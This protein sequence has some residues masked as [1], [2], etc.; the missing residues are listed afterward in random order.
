MFCL[1]CEAASNSRKSL[2]N[3]AFVTGSTNYQRSALTRHTESDDH[4]LSKK[5]LTQKRYM[6]AAQ[7]CA[8]KSV[9]PVLEAQIQTAMWLAEEN[10]P[11]RKFLKLIDLQLANGASAFSNKKGI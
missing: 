1:S 11:N 7:K 10:L 4:A 5:T 8:T 9:L 6:E 3:N 2:K